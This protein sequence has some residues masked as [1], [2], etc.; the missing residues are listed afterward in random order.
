MNNKKSV[1]SLKRNIA[2]SSFSFLGP[3]LW[4][5]EVPR[6]E[7]ESE[8]QL[9]TYTTGT[10]T[11]DP[12]H[13]CDVYHSSRAMQDTKSTEW[14]QGWNPHPHGY[15]SGSLPLSYNRDFKKHN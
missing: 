14:G 8:L 3:L 2:F 5:M 1:L 15:Q 10:T 9:P 12:S 6:L 13:V 7:A 11:Q 4:H